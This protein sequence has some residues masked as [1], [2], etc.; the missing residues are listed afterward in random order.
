LVTV[1]NCCIKPALAMMLPGTTDGGKH[2]E[3]IMRRLSRMSMNG[4][5]W[6]RRTH[7]RWRQRRRAY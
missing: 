3:P 2:V 1:P 6:L 7:Q 4:A 5:H